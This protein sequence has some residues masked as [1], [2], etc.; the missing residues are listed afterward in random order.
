MLLILVLNRIARLL[1]TAIGIKRGQIG[2]GL[3]IDQGSG[4]GRIRCVGILAKAGRQVQGD[5]SYT[6]LALDRTGVFSRFLKEETLRGI[7]L[8]GT[9]RGRG[10]RT[11]NVLGGAC[12]ENQVLTLSSSLV[13]PNPPLIQSGAATGRSG[14]VKPMNMRRG[15]DLL[16]P[17]EGT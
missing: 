4:G 8:R 2:V 10:E 3:W 17:R 14:C 15:L 6:H 7:D 16:L 12:L 11:Q 9:S 1:E 13:M 5:R